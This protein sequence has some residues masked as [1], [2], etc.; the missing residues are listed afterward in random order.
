MPF[1]WALRLQCPVC[2]WKITVCWAGSHLQ[3][4]SRCAWYPPLSFFQSPLNQEWINALASGGD[5]VLC[6]QSLTADFCKSVCC[7]FSVSPTWAGTHWRN[8]ENWA[9]SLAREECTP[10]ITWSGS[11]DLRACRI[12]GSQGK[13]QYFPFVSHSPIGG[14]LQLCKWP[15]FQLTSW[16]T[17]GHQE[18]RGKWCHHLG[19]LM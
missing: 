8:T 13:W 9:V 5:R 6:L 19:H 11:A 3:D 14:A 7:L 15:V 18:P 1:R 12:T 4:G 17:E 16:S 10:W 2:R